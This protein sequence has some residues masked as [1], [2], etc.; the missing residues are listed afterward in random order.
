MSGIYLILLFLQSRGASASL[1]HFFY[2]DFSENVVNYISDFAYA[3]LFLSNFLVYQGKKD[4]FLDR[5]IEK[6][7]GE[8]SIGKNIKRD[9]FLISLYGYKRD[10]K[11]EKVVSSHN[12]VDLKWRF[13]FHI[14]PSIFW[15][16]EGKLVSTNYSWAYGKESNPGIIST[17]YFQIQ[18]GWWNF[19]FDIKGDKRVLTWEKRCGGK[20]SLLTE[21]FRIETE[22]RYR[23]YSYPLPPARERKRE[24]WGRFFIKSNLYRGIPFNFSGEIE[25]R[26]LGFLTDFLRNRDVWEGRFGIR[27]E[28]EYRNLKVLF[29]WESKY[30]MDDFERYLGDEEREGHRY[31]LTLTYYFQKFYTLNLGYEEGIKRYTYPE[32]ILVEDRDERTR[33]VY[34]ETNYNISSFTDASIRLDAERIDLAYLKS[35]R[36]FSTRKTE[37]YRLVG[38]VHYRG[39]IKMMQNME[40]AALYS[41]YKFDPMNNILLRYLE[42]KLNIIAPG[43]STFLLLN[44]RLRCQDQGAFR[45]TIE[46][47]WV[48]FKNIE[49]LELWLSPSFRLLKILGGDIY[50]SGGSYSRFEKIR[51]EER[52]ISMWENNIGVKFKSSSLILNISRYARR[53]EPPFPLIEIVWTTS[54]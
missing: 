35:L 48:Y 20:F 31:S 19:S 6:I 2:R 23:D 40:I 29:N 25:V 17:H 15:K 21:K 51:G 43:D 14:S 41:I 5:K 53:G 7:E 11:R 38:S 4:Y 36:S 52:R 44:F 13:I 32:E 30:G 12:S 46:R 24:K 39:S 9:T 34:L 33:R 50:I 3:N 45:E 16:E 54:F 22:G 8:I 18:K 10:E 26:R 27:T 37:R 42:E 28:R 47:K 1:S 49:Y